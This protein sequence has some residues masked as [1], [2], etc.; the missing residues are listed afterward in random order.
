M[1]IIRL[2][3][4]NKGVSESEHILWVFM[5]SFVLVP[6]SLL[7][8]GLGATYHAHWFAL[9]FAQFAL[10]ISTAISAPVA[11]G[12]AINSYPLLGGELVTTTVLYRNTMLFAMNYGCVVMLGSLLLK[13]S[14]RLT[15]LM[16]YPTLDR[17]TGLQGYDDH[18]RSH[19]PC[20]EHFAVRHDQVREETATNECEE[21]LVT[22]PAGT[23]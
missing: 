2:A 10:S 6:F 9:I 23:S 4:R 5:A 12:Y 18:G 14:R 3:R 8:W 22:G 21:V 11:L 19:R 13:H 1:L 17:G 20:M 7:L 15:S 16:Q